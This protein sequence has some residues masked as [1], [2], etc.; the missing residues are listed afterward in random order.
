MNFRYPDLYC[1]VDVKQ[2]FTSFSEMAR[3]NFK[4]GETKEG[5]EKRVAKGYNVK[6]DKYIILCEVLDCS[7]KREPERYDNVDQV[8]MNRDSFFNGKQ[9]ESFLIKRF[10]KERSSASFLRGADG[11]AKMIRKYCKFDSLLTTDQESI[12]ESIAMYK[13]VINGYDEEDECS[14]SKPKKVKPCWHSNHRFSARIKISPLIRSL[15]SICVIL[16]EG[17]RRRYFRIP[18]QVYSRL[19][20]ALDIYCEPTP[21]DIAHRRKKYPWCFKAENPRSIDSSMDR[22]ETDSRFKYLR[23]TNLESWLRETQ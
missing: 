2:A 19:E 9:G 5:I 13:E 15:E 14:E 6:G 18:N 7:L 1:V 20:T 22:Y 8:L 21:E 12:E 4:F 23:R 17:S 11:F 3:F 16:T 10:P